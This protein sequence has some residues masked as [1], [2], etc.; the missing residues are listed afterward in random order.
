MAVGSF[1][2][3]DASCGGEGYLVIEEALNGRN[4]SE[5]SVRR[6]RFVAALA[7]REFIA[8]AAPGSK[9]EALCREI[10]EWGKSLYTLPCDD[11]AHLIALGARP[12]P[13]QLPI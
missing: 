3:G 6:N 1:I 10:V 4:T 9:T 12:L 8:H 11:N 5:T 13:D 2:P 7:D